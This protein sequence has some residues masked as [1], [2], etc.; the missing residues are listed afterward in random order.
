MLTLFYILNGTNSD[1]DAKTSAHM[2][3]IVKQQLHV[4]LRKDISE[5]PEE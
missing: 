4:Y 1:A 5:T 3:I 2:E